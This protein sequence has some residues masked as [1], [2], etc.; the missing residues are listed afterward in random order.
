MLGRRGPRLGAR[1]GSVTAPGRG[2]RR[3]GDGPPGRRGRR[4]SRAAAARTPAPPPASSA[5]RSLSGRLAPGTAVAVTRE[6][7]RLAPLLQPAA[8]PTV[9]TALVDLARQ[10]GPAM[11]RRLRPRLVAEYGHR[12]AADDLHERLAQAARLSAPRV[13]SGDLTEYQLWTTPEQAAT[14]EAAIGSLSA[15]PPNEETGERDLRPAGQ[16]RVEALT[17]VCRPS[18]AL[19]AATAGDP[20]TSPAVLHVGVDLADLEA[21]TGAGEVLGSTADGTLLPPD[22][23]RRIACDA[24]LVPYVLGTVG[25]VLDVGRVA[26]LFTRA[27]RRLLRRRDRGCTYPG[28]ALAARLGT[29]PPRP[30]LGRR[31]GDRDRERRPPLPAPPHHG[32]PA[33]AVG[34]G[35]RTTRRPRPVRRLGP[36]STAPTTGG[37]T[38]RGRRSPGTTGACRRADPE[39]ARPPPPQA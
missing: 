37:S 27:Q 22:V 13:E 19:D 33:T 5:R 23:L 30:A 38:T 32:P 1:A 29:G 39:G 36:R 15:P 18:S 24:A 25:E 31:R 6:V 26:R 4:R 14:L 11:M 12:G 8:V 28:C 20:S 21:R 34:R 35:P 16:R 10:W 3:R 7:E 2:R 9:T 17:E